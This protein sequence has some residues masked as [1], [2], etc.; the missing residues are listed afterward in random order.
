MKKL[1]F[2]C[3]YKFRFLITPVLTVIF[4]LCLAFQSQAADKSGSCGENLTWT[5]TEGVL[6]I[7]GSG[8]MTDYA[9]GALAPWFGVAKNVRT[10]VMSEEMTSIGDYAFMGCVNVT[11]IVIP[12]SVIE[13]GECSFAQCRTLQYLDL[14]NHLQIIREGAFQECELLPYVEI[15]ASVKEVGANAFYRCY[16]LLAGNIPITVESLGESV[17]SYCTDMIRATIDAPVEELPGWTFYGCSSLSDVSLAPEIV[18]AGKYAF[19]F[20]ENL[21][22]IYSQGGNL[23]TVHSL[24]ESL[25]SQDGAPKEGLLK[26]YEMPKY[27]IVETDDGKAY[28]QIKMIDSEFTITSIR[29]VKEY[30]K[31]QQTEELTAKTMLF[32]EKGWE[33]LS[34]IVKESLEYS[35]I[36]SMVVEI[37]TTAELIES[38]SLE[39]FLEI[40]VQLHIY[41]KS[42]DI[43]KIDMSQATIQT[44]TGQY[45]LLEKATENVEKEAAIEKMISEMRSEEET[46]TSNSESEIVFE[47]YDYEKV[48]NT[49]G[50]SHLVDEDGTTYYVTGRSSRWGITGKEFALYVGLWVASAVLMVAVVML[51]LNQAKKSKEQYEELVKQ[52][53]TEESVAEQ[54]RQLEILREMLGKEE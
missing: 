52:G 41:G 51:S 45:N 11:N 44:F 21:N 34:E 16:S 8:D 18:T 20:C 22:G 15:P 6:I 17:F 39:H 12:E 46:E 10:I 13:I 7:T 27:S 32:N 42:G 36:S 1:I 40:P 50:E 47:P 38:E 54:V 23:E 33:E 49:L 14:G 43:W 3:L 9:D 31:G 37:Y 24:E 35:K 28:A 25:Y 29:V 53:E 5:L 2:K 26:A 19:L 30:E 48:D 4:C